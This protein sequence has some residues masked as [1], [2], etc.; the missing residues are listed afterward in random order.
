MA[1]DVCFSICDAASARAWYDNVQLIHQDYHTA[2]KDAGDI[3]VDTQNFAEGTIV[4]DLVKT[5][6]GMLSAAE[7]TFEAIDSIADTVNKILDIKGEFISGAGAV[8]K[9]VAQIFNV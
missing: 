7:K 3:L 2:I 6:H 4:D 5:G 8:I 1:N 9:T